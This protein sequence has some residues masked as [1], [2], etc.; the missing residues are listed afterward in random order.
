MPLVKD[1]TRPKWASPPP[2]GG[3]GDG[4]GGASGQADLGGPLSPAP[5][6]GV[7]LRG[8]GEALKH[9]GPL[10]GVALDEKTGRLVLLSE[11]QGEIDL[12]PLRLDEVVTV[13][14]SVYEHGEAPFVSIDP[15]P[16]DPLG[17]IMLVRHG[18]AT[19]DTY[20]GWTLLESDRVMKGYSLGYDNLTREPISSRLQSYQDII[21][22]GFST[23]GGNQKDPIW[24]RFWIVP[25]EV[26][27]RQASK[28]AFTLLDVPLKVCTQRMRLQKGKL[29]PA[30][31]AQSLCEDAT[32]TPPAKAFSK[33]FTQHYA[34]IAA[35][36]R[37]LPKDCGID[38]P[39]AFFAELQRLAVITAIAES[40]RDQGMP[41]P[42]WMRDY[43]VK[44]CP[45]AKTTPALTVEA[46]QT[47]GRTIQTQR[48]YGGV[49]LTPADEAVHT[50][51][52]DPEAQAL[53][54]VLAQA[55]DAAPL[56][57]SVAM[58]KD[59]KRYRA[60][61]LPSN[62]TQAL[63]ANRLA[64]TDLIVPV[65]RGT[66]LRLVRHFHSFFAVS[67]VLG[68]AWS[69]DLPR[70]EAQR[71]PV[72][73]TEDKVEFKIVYQLT[74][75]LNSYAE[76]FSE[77]RFVPEAQGQLLVPDHAGN[78]LGVA[79]AKDERIGLPTQVV[80]FRDGR[81]WHFDPS[82]DLAA[83]EETPLTV[84]YRRD[85]TYHLRRIEGWYGKDLRADIRLEH[86]DHGRLTAA[87]GSNGETTR[88]IYDATGAL[89]RVEGPAGI[90][91]YQYQDNLVTAIVQD[92]AVLR[93]FDYAQRGEL[94]QERG[95]DGAEITYHIAS[96]PEGVKVTAVKTAPSD[97]QETVRYDTALRP[98]S[99]TLEDG[100]RVQWHY[101]DRGGIETRLTSLQGEETI[102]SR[103]PGGDQEIWRL[104]GGGTYALEY[105]AGGRVTSVRE[106]D[107]QILRQQ[108]LGD[109]RLATS[110]YETAT[111]HPEYRE[112]GVLTGVL[113]TPPDEG[114]PFNRWLHIQ[115]DE[116][117]RAVEMKDFS[118]A[119]I[120]IGYDATGE[121]AIIVS[122]R[123]G[124]EIKRDAKGKIQTVQTSWGE[125]QH[126]TYDKTGRLKQIEQ[127]WGEAR[128]VIE[129]AQGKPIKVR[130]FDGGEVSLSYY[131]K[132][133]H[134]G[135][136]KQIHAPDDVVISYAYDSADRV[137]TI[138]Y[139]G[140]HRIEYQYDG[141]GRLTGLR[142]APIA[143]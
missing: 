9:L 124:V 3:P 135:Q 10:K 15:N 70:L 46:S 118:G 7:Y 35:E 45:V 98:V 107:R 140:V 95:P 131:D 16:K 83:V 90:R 40:L 122:K 137:S 87:L 75:P 21:K 104:P 52:T 17:P 29:V 47:K 72:R 138:D 116:L 39:V 43:S 18:K 44:P 2:P 11:E 93:Q 77:L 81:H 64:E 86:D 96:A 25:A 92:G 91:E 101:D 120:K 74:S 26:N 109:G 105:D 113:I 79:S 53:A 37:S 56:L 68:H 141:Q 54:P 33:W 67:G 76:T 114:P 110:S 8:A 82:G 73:R 97:S 14:R 42:A 123:D 112:D 136:I 1:D 143:P 94:R 100:A 19:Q 102:V 50:A 4:G 6:G 65:Q 62:D 27:R 106:G 28:Q 12:P 103:S 5:V 115:Y 119:E 134:Q 88:Y 34:A 48:I 127:V 111:M 142:Q 126:N 128:S 24:E 80:L 51:T 99:R 23:S 139:G 59:G 61:A 84:V 55:V 78:I 30:T 71:Q 63:G 49:N 38:S 69:L 133:P 41:F 66:E 31:S 36:S 129:F 57:T 20:G 58:D 121:P 32:S 125:Q 85:E 22:L 60:L 108:W 132:G 13:F 117:G 130:Q 89:T